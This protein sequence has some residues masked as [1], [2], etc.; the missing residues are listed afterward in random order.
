MTEVPQKSTSLMLGYKSG[1]SSW[2]LRGRFMVPSRRPF[3]PTS[4]VDWPSKPHYRRSCLPGRD[5]AQYRSQSLDIWVAEVCPLWTSVDNRRLTRD[6]NLL[7]VAMLEDGCSSTNCPEMRTLDCQ[8]LCATH[9]KPRECPATDY[10]V[11]TLDY[12]TALLNSSKL[13][14]SRYPSAEEWH[15]F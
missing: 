9:D 11:H 14:P 4:L 10:I 5:T 15:W 12:T 7:V 2:F 1:I 6:L 3:K 13:F 8:Y